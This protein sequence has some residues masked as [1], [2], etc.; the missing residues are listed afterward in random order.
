LPFSSFSH[1]FFPWQTAQAKKWL[2]PRH[3]RTFWV[4]Q[5]GGITNTDSG[6]CL[7]PSLGVHILPLDWSSPTCLYIASSQQSPSTLQLRIFCKP[8]CSLPLSLGMCQ[9]VQSSSLLTVL[10]LAFPCVFNFYLIKE[11]MLSN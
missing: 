7:S 2:F 8:V 1:S 5:K 3:I 4:V 11:Q 9:D 6:T 10:K